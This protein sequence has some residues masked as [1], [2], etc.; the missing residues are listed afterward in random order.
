MSYFSIRSLG[1]FLGGERVFFEALWA[2]RFAGILILCGHLLTLLLLPTVLTKKKRQPV[3]TVAWFL[4]ILLLP[5]FGGILYLL[6]GIN[7]VARRTASKR[8]AGDLLAD[9][10]RELVQFQVLPTELPD[11]HLQPLARLASKIGGTQP[12]LGNSVQIFS[13]TSQTFKAIKEAIDNATQTIHLEYYIWQPDVSGTELRDLLIKKAQEG[14]KVRFLYDALGSMR[15]R[16]QF[17]EPMLKAGIQVAT[18]LPGP[19]FR[20][21]WSINLRSHRKIVVVDGQIGF[22]GGMNI[23]D[24][25]LGRSSLGYWRDT[26]LVLRGPTVLQL[27][28]V[29]VEDWFFATGEQLTAPELFPDA[30][31]R[32]DQ[33][34]QVIAGGPDGES[35]IL[36]SLFF[37]ALNEAEQRITMATSYFVPTQPLVAALESAAQRGVRVRLLLAGNSAHLTTILAARSYYDTLLANGVEIYEYTGGLLHSKTLTIDGV[38]SFVGTPNFDARSLILNFEVGVILYGTRHAAELERHFEADLEK[39]ER[40]QLAGWDKRS[41]LTMVAENFCR[42]FSPVL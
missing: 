23:G 39:A 12:T 31:D 16:R 10:M 38:W 21:R 19:T 7:Q 37:A 35:E 5:C 41:K 24:E 13:K 6:L 8:Q 34:A 42:L 18:F 28:Q 33:T 15:I 17:L 2:N 25:Y 14:I 1:E 9:Q 30:S 40:I 3:S 32:G 29:F 26:H 27:Q 20:E 36:H 22:T 11:T 4:M